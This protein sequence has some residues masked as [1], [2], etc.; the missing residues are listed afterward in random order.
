MREGKS[1][2]ENKYIVLKTS[3]AKK[4]LTEDMNIMLHDI[5]LHIQSERLKENKEINEYLIVNSDEAYA[6][7][8]WEI[9]KHG[10]AIKHT[11][12]KRV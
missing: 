5:C 3:D 9:I 2:I 11:K 6:K 12:L 4:Y 8:V 1:P 7:E 10:E